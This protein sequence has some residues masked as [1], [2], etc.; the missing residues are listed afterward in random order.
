MNRPTTADVLAALFTLTA[1]H[2]QS[3]TYQGVLSDSSGNPVTAPQDFQF[4]IL[5]A[6]SGGSAI[7]AVTTASDVSPDNGRFTATVSPR[8]QRLH[9]R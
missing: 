5:A 7:G 2:A 1:A 6:P 8:R 3:F 9:R 4:T